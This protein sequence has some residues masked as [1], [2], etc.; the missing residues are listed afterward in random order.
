MDQRRN[1]RAWSCRRLG[2]EWSCFVT[3]KGQNSSQRNRHA[4]HW[5]QIQIGH[6]KHNR[7]IRFECS[8]YLNHCTLNTTI[9]LNT[10]CPTLYSLREEW[11][12]RAHTKKPVESH[13]WYPYPRTARPCF[14]P[15]QLHIHVQKTVVLRSDHDVISRSPL[16]FLGCAS[17]YISLKSTGRIDADSESHDGVGSRQE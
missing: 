2:T 6:S 4:Q 13:E 8:V 14:T 17:L 16:P 3:L 7:P 1:P 12:G 15:R 10:A 5:P 11:K 9:S